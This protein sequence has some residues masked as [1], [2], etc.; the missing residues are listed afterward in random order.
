MSSPPLPTVD[1]VTPCRNRLAD[2]RA[3]L[4]SWLAH[5]LIRRVVVVDFQSQ[6]PVAEALGPDLDPRLSVLRVEGEPL[7]RQGR[8]QNVGLQAS[9]ADLILKLDADTAVVDITPYVEAMARN[10]NLFL[11]GCS[12]QGSSSGLCLVPRRMARRIG[13]YHDHMAGWGGDDVDFYRRLARAGLQSRTV[14]PHHFAEASQP[15]AVKNSETPQLDSHWLPPHSDLVRQPQFTAFR[16]GLLARIQPQ[17]RHSALRWHIPTAVGPGRSDARLRSS[18]RMRLLLARHNTELANI[19]A[20][21]TY[22]PGASHWQVLRQPQIQGLIAGHRLLLP[23]QR[24]ER[25]ALL[26]SLPHRSRALRELARSLAV[27]LLSAE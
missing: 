7:W 14:E 22:T 3:S 5:P 17:Q 19:L 11:Q 8:A 21:H 16:N 24:G 12:R 26:A 13:G 4:P 2:L 1:L 23:R 18:N 27:E 10:P 20:L 9:D 6:R 25:P 15:M